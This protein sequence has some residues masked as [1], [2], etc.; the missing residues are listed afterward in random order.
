MTA[1]IRRS[2]PGLALAAA[3]VFFTFGPLGFLATHAL[4]GG[5]EVWAR[6]APLDPATT[7]L[8]VALLATAAT[9]WAMALGLPLAWLTV[10]SDLPGRRLLRWLAPLPLAVPPYIGALVYQLLL[11]PGGLLAQALG[12]GRGGETPALPGV[13]IYGLGGAAWVLGLFTYP[14]VFLLVSGALERTN[15]ALEEAARAAG[16]RRF[17]VLRRVTLPLLRPALLGSG[18]MVFLYA[19][20]DFGVVSLLRVRTLTTVIYD[21]VQGTM[22]WALP[23]TL[24]LL[25]SAI[26]GAVLAAQL[27]ILGRARYTQI[28][29]AA[30]PPR[31]AP[32]GRWRGAAAVYAWTVVSAGLLVPVAVLVV[33]A[34]RL[35]P[36]LGAFVVGQR[37]YLWNSVW[38]AFAGATVALCL[39]LA[40]GWLEERRG[41]PWRVSTLFQVGYAIPGTVM[42]LGLVGFL[43][44]AL[45]WVYATPLTLVV[46]YLVLYITPA[47][48]AA[49]AAFAQLHVSLEEAARALG[50]PP[51][52]TFRTITLPLVR[53]GLLSGW[54]LV[55]GLSIR[56]LAAT[57]IVRPPGFDT[58]PVRIWIHTMDVG[59]EPRA[60]ALALVLVAL[61]ALPWLAFLAFGRRDASAAV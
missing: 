21:Y 56:E 27:S 3:A 17:E 6:L 19:W 1:A 29:S 48:Q 16:A 33:E 7:I 50:R 51:L 25:L 12:L 39:S 61:T 32:L 23:A 28:G 43:H 36:G 60:A 8:R 5:G 14:Y 44:A 2:W 20:A 45:P 30:R 55:F 13:S 49:K 24:A 4:P 18:L 22:D 35:G 59:P 58:L 57:L 9:A 11:A 10:R 47:C 52:A 38:T 40:V 46:A 26:T 53:P 15:P 34:L 31:P 54:L 42:G 41:L 37:G